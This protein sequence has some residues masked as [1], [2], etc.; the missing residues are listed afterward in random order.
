MATLHKR[1]QNSSAFDCDD[2]GAEPSAQDKALF[3]LLEVMPF[4]GEA[5]RFA[6]QYGGKIALALAAAVVVVLGVEYVG[7]A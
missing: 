7:S 6:G 3:A 1:A 4:L 5:N 2:Y